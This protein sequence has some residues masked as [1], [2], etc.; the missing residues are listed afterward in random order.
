M[1]RFTYL[2]NVKDVSTYFTAWSESVKV[3]YL[4]VFW[5]LILTPRNEKLFH[6]NQG[7]C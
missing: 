1:W 2:R 3:F 4:K 7:N 6:G 5:T